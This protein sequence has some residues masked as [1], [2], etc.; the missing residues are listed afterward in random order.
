MNGRAAIS[1]TLTGEIVGEAGGPVDIVMCSLD[2][3]KAAASYCR[4][5]ADFA[6]H[7]PKKTAHPVSD[8]ALSGW[9]VFYVGLME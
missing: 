9:Q 6:S 1:A 7:G 3:R 5:E 4:F 2:Q 8:F